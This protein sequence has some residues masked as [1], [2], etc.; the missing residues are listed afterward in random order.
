MTRFEF[1]GGRTAIHSVV[2]SGLYT[3]WPFANTRPEE[4]ILDGTVRIEC[5]GICV[6]GIASTRIVSEAS[7]YAVV[8]V[9]QD[10]AERWVLEVMLCK[11]DG[12]R[13]NCRHFLA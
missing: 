10:S 6:E 8:G 7:G 11:A 5:G 4:L 3:P 2:S 1:K 13:Q 9:A 12:A